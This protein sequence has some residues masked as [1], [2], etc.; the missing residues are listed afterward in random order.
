[1][2]GKHPGRRCVPGSSC[3]NGRI[4][5]CRSK[6]LML[7]LLVPL[8]LRAD[9]GAASIAEGG[10]VV[11]KRETRIVMAKEVLQISPTKVIVDYDFRNDS[12]Q[13]ITTTVAFP[14]PDYE[15][16]EQEPSKQGFDDFQLWIN[17]APVHYQVETRAFLKDTEYTALLAAM[18]ID[19]GSFGHSTDFD[20]SADVLKLMIDQ[21]RKLVAAGLIDHSDNGSTQMNGQPLWQVRKKYYWQ[22]TFPAHQTVH[23]HH[24][25]SPV[26]GANNSIKFGMGTHPSDPWAVGQ[27]KSF[28]IEGSLRTSLQ[29]IADSRDKNAPYSYVDFI[30]TSANTWKTPIEDFTLIVERPHSKSNPGESDLADYVSFCW[31]GPVTKIDADHFS[32]HVVGFVPSK[33]LRVGFFGVMRSRF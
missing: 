12:D 23:I 17:D 21:R 27:L 22:Q 30:L 20:H 13:D 3:N 18:H 33:E 16:S 32:A 28:C 19:I 7:A 14:I 1:V 6:F 4:V 24:E 15:M 2:R 10:V 8:Q 29:Q 25:Y 11:M 5:T 31:D 26:V 9:D